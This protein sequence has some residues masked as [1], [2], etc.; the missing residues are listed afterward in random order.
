MTRLGLMFVVALAVALPASAQR[1]AVSAGL[2]PEMAGEAF[3]RAVIEVCVPAV[4]GNGVSS[5]GAART[6]KLNPTQ[7]AEVRRQAGAGADETVW[8]L[9]EA[10]GV[11]TVREAAGR[12]TVSVYGPAV[13]PTIVGAMQA[14]GGAGFEATAGAAGGEGFRQTLLG[15]QG[16]KRVSV[17]L[18][19]AEPGSAGHQSRFSVTT[20]TV[21]VA[22]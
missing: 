5:L 4:G 8:E 6:G 11:V 3:A 17:Q 10:R 1:S 18:A 16:G 9:V 14:L 12:C 13:A 22:Q 20:A 2:S 19:G 15:T 21:F 7:D